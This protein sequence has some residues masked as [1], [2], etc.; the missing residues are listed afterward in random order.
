MTENVKSNVTNKQQTTTAIQLMLLQNDVK[1][2]LSQ[3]HI[4]AKTYPSQTSR[5]I[6]DKGLFCKQEKQQTEWIIIHFTLFHFNNH[7]CNLK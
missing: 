4:C 5:I 1:I 7:V 6:E 2:L 3:T